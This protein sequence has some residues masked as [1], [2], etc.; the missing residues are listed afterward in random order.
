M[1]TPQLVT[2]RDFTTSRYNQLI[3]NIDVPLSDILARSEAIIQSQ[4]KIA[5]VPTS[6]TEEFYTPTQ[7]VFVLNRPII[8]LTSLKRRANPLYAWTTLDLTSV[9]IT[10]DGG[11]LEP[12]VD[13]VQGY[14]VQVIYTAGVS[15]IPEDIRE[16]I[17]M[18]AT[19]LA[20]VDLEVYGSGDGRAPGIQYMYEDIERIVSKHRRTSTVFH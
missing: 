11:Y 13:T 19:L 1:A 17:L 8:T 18:Q 4:L 7:T 16:A 20:F 12:L 9:R 15:T 2:L 10:N 6:Y 5:L 14:E 3:D